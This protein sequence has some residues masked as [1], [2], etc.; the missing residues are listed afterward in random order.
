MRA[1]SDSLTSGAVSTVS[2][3][4]C[5]SAEIGITGISARFAGSSVF[6]VSVIW[7]KSVFAVRTEDHH[8][9]WTRLASWCSAATIQQQLP[10]CDLCRAAERNIGNVCAPLFRT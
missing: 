9:I 3:V 8:N 1:A 10:D 4:R 5:I 6:I 7:Y 2:L